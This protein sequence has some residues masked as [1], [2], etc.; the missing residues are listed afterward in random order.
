[1][2]RVTAK[3]RTKHSWSP[4]LRFHDGERV[5][6]LNTW[7][8]RADGVTLEQCMVRTDAGAYLVVLRDE[9]HRWREKKDA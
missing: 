4:R 9:L 3:L 2:A 1:M 5:T 8:E 6:V 7:T